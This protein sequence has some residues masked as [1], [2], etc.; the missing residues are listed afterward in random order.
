MLM[1]SL[2][3]TMQIKQLMYYPLFVDMTRVAEATIRIQK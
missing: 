3:L 2:N 1:T